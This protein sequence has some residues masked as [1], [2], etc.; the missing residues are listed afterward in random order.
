M[1]LYRSLSQFYFVKSLKN[2]SLSNLW[3]RINNHITTFMFFGICIILEFFIITSFFIYVLT[4]KLSIISSLSFILIY[5]NIRYA[6]RAIDQRF[7]DL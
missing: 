7:D 2:N 5:L 4:I 1:D 3:T 6:K